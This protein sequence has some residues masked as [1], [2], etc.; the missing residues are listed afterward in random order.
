MSAISNFG[1][2]LF[3]FLPNLDGRWMEMETHDREG[4]SYINVSDW[5]RY[6]YNRV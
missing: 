6:D 4:E 3:F 2:F 5:L 1:R